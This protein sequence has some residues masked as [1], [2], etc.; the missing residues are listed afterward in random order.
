MGGAGSQVSWIHSLGKLG[1]VLAHWWVE[2]GPGVT[3]Y[4]AGVLRANVRLLMGRTVAWREVQGLLSAC[5]WEGPIPDM[6]DCGVL[7][8]LELVSAHWLG[9]PCPRGCWGLRGPME[10]GLLVDGTVSLPG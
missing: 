7:G 4:R 3:G 2:P 9:R 6:A 10:T 5:W 1:L 8:I